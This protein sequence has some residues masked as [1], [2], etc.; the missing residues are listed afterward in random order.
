MKVQINRFKGGGT[1][2]GVTLSHGVADGSGMYRLI[3]R[4]AELCKGLGGTLK[5]SDGHPATNPVTDNREVLQAVKHGNRDH[6]QLLKALAADNRLPPR[7]VSFRQ[8]LVGGMV[9]NFVYNMAYTNLF[10]K[11]FRF[12]VTYTAEDV[13][14]MKEVAA[15]QLGVPLGRESVASLPI[16][17]T[18]GTTVD[19]NGNRGLSANEVI[20]AQVVRVFTAFM[21]LGGSPH[22]TIGIIYNARNRLPALPHNYIGNLSYQVTSSGI[23]SLGVGA[24]LHD[25]SLGEVA[26]M[27]K[28]QVSRITPSLCASELVVHE[29]CY[30]HGY[31]MP[32]FINDEAF[33]VTNN[34]SGFPTYETDFGT[35]PPVKHIPHNI[36]DN[37]LI[38]RGE[39]PG[40]F[41][42]F[43]SDLAKN[44][45]TGPKSCRALAEEPW[46]SKFKVYE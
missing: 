20:S 37:F 23:A 8:F 30:R 25:R 34:H 35:G 2:V 44:A 36:G 15:A 13:R 43:I 21:G 1:I 29:D 38:T 41:N 33:L 17:V 4:W 10:K 3:H 45:L 9:K 14:K 32:S 28:D 11:R 7:I 46:I 42:V 22:L 40:S 26:S 6:K 31:F 39:S 18:R 19:M 12:K 24:A 5:G 27:F 16:G